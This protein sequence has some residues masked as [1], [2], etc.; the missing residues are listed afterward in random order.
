M[1]QGTAKTLELEVP[2]PGAGFKTVIEFVA[3][4]EI[5]AAEIW[6]VSRVLSTKV[7]CRV[8]PFHCTVELEIKFVPTT[9]NT[10][11][12]PPGLLLFGDTVTIAGTA[13][14]LGGG[15]EDPPPLVLPAPPPQPRLAP[16]RPEIRVLNHRTAI[17]HLGQQH[18]LPFY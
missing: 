16:R 17:Y 5:S 6:A 9:L 15:L 4:V 7:V 11:S 12:A 3:S 18:Y 14:E 1:S 13:F 8:L 2:P 10:K